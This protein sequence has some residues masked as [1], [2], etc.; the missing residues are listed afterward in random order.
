MQEFIE[1]KPF[2]ALDRGVVLLCSGER[3]A[4]PK[5]RIGTRTYVNRHTMIDA[6]VSIEIGEDCGIGPFCYITDHDHGFEEGKAPLQGA[7]RSQPTRIGDRVWIGAQVT[8]LKGVNIGEGAVIGAGSVVTHDIPPSSI[9]VGI[10]AR[11]L[12][13]VGG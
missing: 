3:Q 9:A 6:A 7:L 5:I 2:C 10:P 4:E 11:V 8:V 12:R 1:L 13:Q